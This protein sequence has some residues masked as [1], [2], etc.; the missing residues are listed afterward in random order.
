MRNGTTIKFTEENT[1][2]PIQANA[3]NTNVPV[4]HIAIAFKLVLVVTNRI[5]TNFIS[6]AMNVKY[7]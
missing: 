7:Q 4:T 6:K 5:N 1:K 2:P 3:K